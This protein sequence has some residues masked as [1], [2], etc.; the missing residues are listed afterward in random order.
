MKK[1]KRFLTKK[2]RLPSSRQLKAPKKHKKT[3]KLKKRRAAFR[4]ILRKAFDACDSSTSWAAQQEAASEQHN[5]VELDK[6]RKRK[7]EEA[8]N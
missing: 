8:G 1:T 6:K 3:P 5:I 7:Q 4:S 2:A